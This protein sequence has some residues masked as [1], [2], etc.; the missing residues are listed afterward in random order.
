MRS[1]NSKKRPEEGKKSPKTGS[2]LSDVP[3]SGPAEVR[4]PVYICAASAASQRHASWPFSCGGASPPRS[5]FGGGCGRLWWRSRYWRWPRRKPAA[6]SLDWVQRTAVPP[7]FHRCRR[8]CAC[9]SHLSADS[10]RRP[11]GVRAGQCLGWGTA[12]V[13]VAAGSPQRALATPREVNRR[14]GY[15]HRASSEVGGSGSIC[16]RVSGR[17]KERL[18]ELG[19]GAM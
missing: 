16:G 13:F 8:R 10:P 18:G 4:R 5:L 1:K 6:A 19:W 17:A 7:R 2:L 15:L 9:R 3:K 11:R 14:F 12:G